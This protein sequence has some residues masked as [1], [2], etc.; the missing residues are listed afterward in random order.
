MIIRIRHL[1]SLRGRV[2][3]QALLDFL[4]LVCMAPQPGEVSTADLRQRWA[5]SQSQVSRRLHALAAAGLAEI[6][7]G[8][9]AYQVHAIS[10][11]ADSDSHG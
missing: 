4:T 6:T 10:T 9:G 8:Y 7:P 5:C 2:A 1:L 11:L 3:D